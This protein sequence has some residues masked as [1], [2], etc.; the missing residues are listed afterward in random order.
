MRVVA[1]AK[2]LCPGAPLSGVL[3]PAETKCWTSLLLL[4]L[5]EAADA[6]AAG[7]CPALSPSQARLGGGGWRRRCW[8]R[9]LARWW[10][11]AG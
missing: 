2:S 11:L 4:T 10:W 5:A 1:K 3:E 6:A 7:F 9:R 8:R